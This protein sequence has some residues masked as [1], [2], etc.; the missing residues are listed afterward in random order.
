M[1]GHTGIP[2]KVDLEAPLAPT[3]GHTNL[4]M[5]RREEGCRPT[6]DTVALISRGPMGV[7]TTQ[8][9]LRTTSTEPALT[10]KGRGRSSPQ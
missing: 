4:V 10:N 8:A 2:G 1:T 3:W 9:P 6:Q 5:E 7:E